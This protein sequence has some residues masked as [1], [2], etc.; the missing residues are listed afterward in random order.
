MSENKV[1]VSIS[2]NGLDHLVGRLWFRYRKDKDSASFEYDPS[3]LNNPLSFALE[4][5]LTLTEGSFHTEANKALFGAIGDSAPDRWGRILM[6]RSEGQ[7]ALL[8]QRA[9]HTLN[10]LDYLLGVHDVSRQ[11]ALRFSR[12]INGPYLSESKENAIPPLIQLPQLLSATEHF[13]EDKADADDLQLLLAPGSSLGGARPKASIIDCENQLSIAKFPHKEDEFSTVQWEAVALT[14]A[15]KAGLET[16]K[17]WLQKINHKSVL[18]IQRFDRQNSQRI[19]FISAMSMI[20]AKDNEQ[21]SYLELVDSLRQYGARPKQD[22]EQLWRR[23]VF[24][25][26]ISNTDDHLKNHGF[27]YCGEQGWMLSPVYDVNPTPTSI[28]PRILTTTIDLDNGTAS[29]DL[30]LSVANEF[31]LKPAEANKIIQSVGIAVSEW[32]GCAS[33]IGISSA[34]IQHMKTAFEHEDLKKALCF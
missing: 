21:H 22:M 31:G 5:A 30:A 24:S 25:I 20:G 19:P 29:L 34:E 17:W 11:G 18:I 4:P 13:I 23:I 33:H 2:L 26:L 32:K 10:E 1:T 7:N 8:E 27:L 9:R 12:E 6:R 3:W 16:P 28:K 15:K 14:L